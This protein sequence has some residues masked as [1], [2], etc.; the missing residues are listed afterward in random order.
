M[1]NK[2]TRML[3]FLKRHLI[4]CSTDTKASAYLL[5]VRPIMD[6]ACAVWDPHYVTDITTLEKI[7]RRAARW[8]L[9]DYNYFSSVSTML[10]HL[11]WQPLAL[12]RKQFRLHLFYQTMY[13]LIG[14]SLPEYYLPTSRHTRQHHPLHLIIPSSNT[15]AYMTSFFPNTLKD[16]N[17][18]PSSTIENTDY[19]TFSATLTNYL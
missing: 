3:N 11:K 7:Q 12:R 15:T 5:L 2:A 18:L 14:L 19:N 1:P 10:N 17:Q 8:A 4:K 6:Y 9:S 16:W 13:N